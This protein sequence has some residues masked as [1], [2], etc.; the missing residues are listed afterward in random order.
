MHLRPGECSLA[1]NGVL[2]LDELGEFA[3]SALEGLRE[4][5]EE[6]VIR[7]AR[8]NA[9]AVLPARFVLVGATNPCPCGGGAPGSCQCDE[10][11]RSRYLRRLSGPLADRFDL[12]VVVHRPSVDDL[13]GLEAGE[14]S[15]RGPRARG[16]R[17]EAAADRGP[18]SSTPAL[19]SDELDTA[20]PL[21]DDA[22]AVL[23]A[24]VERDR[25]TGRGYHRIRRVARTIADLRRTGSR[26]G[27][28]APTSSWPCRCARRC[29]ADDRGADAMDR[30][31]PLRS[32]SLVAAIGYLAAL[33]GLELVTV[34]RLRTLLAHHDPEEAFAVAAGRLR[35]APDG[36]ADAARRGRPAPGG[37][38]R[39][40]AR[41]SGVGRAVPALGIDAVT[42]RDPRPIPTCS[43]LDPQPP[44]VL[45]WPR[46]L[47]DARRPRGGHRR[48]PQRDR[49][50]AARPRA[51]SAPTSPP[52]ASASC[53]AWP[54]ASTPRLTTAP[55]GS[56][57]GR[58]AG[59]V[60]NG[61]DVGV[62]PPE[63]RPVGRG[64]QPGACCCRSGHR[65]PQP[66]RFRF[67]LRNRVIAALSEIARGGREPRDAAGR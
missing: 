39:L 42:A 57:G 64:G 5:L 66:E 61:L 25:L 50:R 24:E 35:A 11:A 60:A 23:R 9:R 47:V 33:A 30:L 44:A 2:F 26:A 17:P 62:P 21:A 43:G 54:A 67:P 20:A 63:R 51:G 15:A 53:Q 8:A 4:P 22:R 1:H 40:A 29:R 45:F 12:R 6:G 46:R 3:R 31:M 55:C 14:P 28:A 16:R 65:G 58:A 32:T 34:A 49:H 18:A 52:P 37:T 48:H 27:R 10:T 38:R 7:V 59:V 36:R 13:F 41:S 19:D 56:S